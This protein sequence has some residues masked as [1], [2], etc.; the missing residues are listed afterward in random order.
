MQL[1]ARKLSAIGIIFDFEEFA[2]TGVGWTPIGAEYQSQGFT[3]SNGRF[4]CF[5]SGDSFYAGSATLFNDLVGG[6]TTIT[7]DSGDAFDLQQVDLAPVFGGGPSRV[8][9]A[10]FRDG[11]LVAEQ[12]IVTSGIGLV[13]ETF[14]L[15]DAFNDVDRVEITE[16][17]PPHYQ[18]DNVIIRFGRECYAD[19]DASGV[20]DFF[21]FLCFQNAF[22]AGDPYADC[23]DSGVLDLFDFLCFQNSFAAGCP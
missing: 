19:C 4:L 10:G 18:M 2:C 9:F 11:A 20:Y 15:D 1:A 7:A 3:F 21:D 5:C 23:D 22:G 6:K 16:T 14:E 8:G 13:L 12:T 17:F